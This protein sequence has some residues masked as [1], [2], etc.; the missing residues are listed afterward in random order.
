MAIV[1]LAH[2]A[3]CAECGAT[4]KKG[5][6]VKAYKRSNGAVIYYGFDCHKR[7]VPQ[8]PEQTPYKAPQEL[9]IKADDLLSEILS[10]LR[11]IRDHL[12]GNTVPT[13]QVV[14]EVASNSA[15]SELTAKDWARFWAT[16]KKLGLD[17]EA[18]YALF[19]TRSLKEQIRT[20]ADLEAAIQTMKE[21]TSL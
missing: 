17:K 1:K 5:T 2:D 4:L 13:E 3:V 19:Q 18:V 16:A 11:Q 6:T 8:A 7:Q 9:A 10:V 21:M 20:R 15:P 12:I 14:E